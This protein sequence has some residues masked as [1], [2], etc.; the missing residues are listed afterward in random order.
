MRTCN[1]Y[2]RYIFAS[3][4]VQKVTQHKKWRISRKLLF[5]F[6]YNAITSVVVTNL[7]AKIYLSNRVDAFRYSLIFF[8]RL[9]IGV[10][11]SHV[12]KLF[13]YREFVENMH[14]RCIRIRELFSQFESL[15][16]IH[17]QHAQPTE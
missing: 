1:V 15:Y 14:V 6:T 17:T 5:F 2:T 13:L 10:L 8:C 16:A 3:K 7:P 11:R 9:K 12:P 4:F